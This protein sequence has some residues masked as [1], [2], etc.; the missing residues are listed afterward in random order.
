MEL[1]ELKT[2][3][4]NLSAEERRKIALYILELEKD[5]FKGTLGPKIVGDLEELSRVVQESAEKIR[6]YVKDSL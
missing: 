6:K 4:K 2:A 1:A 5:H 3:L